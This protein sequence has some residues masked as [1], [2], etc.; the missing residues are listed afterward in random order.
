MQ[1]MVGY[2]Q[3]REVISQDSFTPPPCP[4]PPE[5]LG[6][7]L[8][9]LSSSISLL[10]ALGLPLFVP[11]TMHLGLDLRTFSPLL[12]CNSLQPLLTQNGLFP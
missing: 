1:K 6:V 9:T 12:L 10:S 2:F 11:C 4:F 5:V 3:H 8:V 7:N